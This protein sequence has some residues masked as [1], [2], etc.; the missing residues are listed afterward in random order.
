MLS[1]VWEKIFITTNRAVQ[2]DYSTD[3]KKKVE[4][5]TS[6]IGVDKMLLVDY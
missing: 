3:N 5:L 2:M 4:A 6:K 1:P